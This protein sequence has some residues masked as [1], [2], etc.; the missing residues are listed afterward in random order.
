MLKILTLLLLCAG[1]VEGLAYW[2]M[3]PA[4][5]GLGKPVLV[6]EGNLSCAAPG[7]ISNPQS[8]IPDP[9]DT[10]TPLPEI[11]A[12]SLAALRCTDGNALRIDRGDGS[13][14]H[15]AFFEWDYDH[16]AHVLE[17]FKH[18]PEQCLGSI[19]LKLIERLPPET[20][21]IGPETLTFDHSV[22]RDPGGGIVHAFKSTWISGSRDLIGG[23]IRS[24]NEQLR[25][26]RIKAAWNRYRP[27]YARVAQGAV[28]GIP[29]PGLAWQAFEETTLK[30]LKFEYRPSF[31]AN[32]RRP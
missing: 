28:R 7:T 22:F 8:Q 11:V 31:P 9:P 1:A 20:F 18:L 19:G 14:I 21:A 13:T 30:D 5:A 24:A 17:A 27:A 23:D 32:T 26:L 25:S 2:W 12:S 4:P 16:S 6:Y 3:H 15:F 29:H 10:I